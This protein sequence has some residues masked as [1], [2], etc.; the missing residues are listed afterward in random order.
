MF[1]FIVFR[2][3]FK[4]NMLKGKLTE[5]TPGI[6]Y[7]LHVPLPLFFIECPHQASKVIRHVYVC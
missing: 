5:I 4:S 6:N 3:H 2:L 7:Y 1:S